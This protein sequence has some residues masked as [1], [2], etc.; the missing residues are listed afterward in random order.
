VIDLLST[1]FNASE[2]YMRATTAIAAYELA[3][4]GAPG[5]KPMS[6]AEAIEFAAKTVKDTHTAGMS[7]VSPE[8]FK[9]DFGRVILTFKKIGFQQATVIALAFHRAFLKSDL[10]PKVKD[11]ARR[12][13][14]GIFGMS[15]AFLGAAGLPFYGAFSVLGR[16]LAAMFGDDDDEP[17]DFNMQMREISGDFYEGLLAKALNIDISKR[18]ALASD[19][20]WRDDPLSV[21]NYGYARTLMM[22]LMGPMGNYAINAERAVTEIERGNV[23]RGI[24][25]LLPTFIANGMKGIRYM[26]EGA[27]TLDGDPI[28]SDISVWS[29]LKQMA[30]FAPADLA[31]LQERR[32]AAK[33]YEAAVLARKQRIL[34]GYNMARADGDPDMAREFQKQAA[35]FRRKYPGLMGTDTLQRSV[36]SREAAQEEMMRGIRISKSLQRDIEKRF[37]L[38]ED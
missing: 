13:L 24:E 27:E 5:Q 28:E 21:Q 25:T 18:A 12:Q 29:G 17:Y 14:L 31:D 2:R 15:G 37:K 34:D 23:E 32:S 38:G 33:Q 19:V 10:D 7:E 8:Y 20:L 26:S 35:E 9:N 22:N 11:V 30:G 6:E 36:R 16:M 3:R 1:P 4:K